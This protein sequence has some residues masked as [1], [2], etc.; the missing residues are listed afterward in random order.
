MMVLFLSSLNC[1]NFPHLNK[2]YQHQMEGLKRFYAYVCV[3][4]YLWL[5][6][7]QYLKISHIC[8]QFIEI[9]KNFI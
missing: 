3:C 5:S 1:E 4:V 2:S 6:F 9:S 7:A 8:R